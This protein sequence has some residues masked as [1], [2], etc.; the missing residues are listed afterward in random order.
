MSGSATRSSPDTS[1]RTSGSR[2]PISP[3]ATAPRRNPIREALQLLRGEGFVIIEPNRGA[4]V[5]PIDEDFVRDIIEIE[6]LIEP[7]LTR[8]FVSIVDRRRH[9]AARGGPGRD[10]GARLRRPRPARPARHPLPPDHLRPPLQPA[11]GRAVVEAPRDPARDQPPLPDVAEPP[12]GGDPRAP[13]AHRAA[14]K[15]R[16]PTARRPIVAGHV[17]GSGRHIIEQMG[18]ARRLRRSRSTKEGR[19]DDHDRRH[20]R[21]QRAHGLRPERAAHHRSPGRDDPRP[22]LLPDPAHR[23]QPGRLRPRRGPRRRE[24]GHRAPAQAPAARAEPLQRRLPV[25]DDQPATAPTAARRAASAA[26]R[27]R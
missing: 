16:T 27:S 1:G 6:V 15:R 13:R 2:S 24:P 25:Q 19:D 14:A 10:R 4:R 17:E 7:A 18:V 22:R 20:D 9:R 26:S 23:H 3:R 8:W 12:P 21:R 5:R 11:R